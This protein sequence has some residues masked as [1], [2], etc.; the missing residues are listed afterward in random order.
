MMLLKA[1]ASLTTNSQEASSTV[2]S[3]LNRFCTSK[4][5]LFQLWVICTSNLR[6]WGNLQFLPKKRRSRLFPS[7]QK[8]KDLSRTLFMPKIIR[9]LHLGLMQKIKMVWINSFRSILWVEI[10]PSIKANHIQCYMR[11]LNQEFRNFHGQSRL[12]KWVWN[13]KAE[14]KLIVFSISPRLTK[15]QG[16]RTNLEERVWIKTAVAT[17]EMRHQAVSPMSQTLQ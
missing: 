17:W 6:Y 12:L 11:K 2:T 3:L 15:T 8:M 16:S 10:Q 14:V 1:L 9:Q 7:M 4:T 13:L 5:R